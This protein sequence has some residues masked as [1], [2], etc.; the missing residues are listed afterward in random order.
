MTGRFLRIFVILMLLTLATGGASLA[1]QGPL[2]GDVTIT[3]GVQAAFGLQPSWAE[4]LTQTARPPLVVATIVVGAG[5]AWLAASWRVALA[6][7]VAFGLAWLTDMIL[8]AAILVPR[9][10]P[11]LV[12]VASASDSSGL[13]STFGLN[14]G[15]IFGVV[16]I[17]VAGSR[18]ALFMRGLALAVVVAGSSARVVLGGH[19]PSQMLASVLLGLLASLVAC[20]AI[21]WMPVKRSDQ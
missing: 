4:W 3:R 17:V 15:S 21:D 16:V 13:P 12:A 18:R 14:Y 8:R 10:S 1:I 7:P 19:W 9:P 6:V 2:P 11:D 5:M 20:K